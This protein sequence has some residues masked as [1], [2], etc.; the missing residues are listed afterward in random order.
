MHF[1]LIFLLFQGKNFLLFQGKNF[2]AIS[3]EEKREG[4]TGREFV[5]LRA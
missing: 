2:F 3:L 1:R 5:P 4:V